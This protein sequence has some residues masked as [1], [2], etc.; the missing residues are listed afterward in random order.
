MTS[1]QTLVEHHTAG[2]LAGHRAL[3]M[4]PVPSLYESDSPPQSFT[5]SE[6]LPICPPYRRAEV[7]DYPSEAFL[8][9]SRYSI[10]PLPLFPSLY[11][12]PCQPRGV[13]IC[14]R[15]FVPAGP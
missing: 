6:L 8:V 2:F 15:S 14:C 4:C 13:V 5:P 12:D 7:C 10:P 11:P 3:T 1:P 9:S